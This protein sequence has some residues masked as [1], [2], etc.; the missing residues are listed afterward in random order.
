MSEKVQGVKG[1]RAARHDLVPGYPISKLAEVFGFGTKKYADRNWEMGYD[2]GKSYAAAQ[3]HLLA[4]WNG[5]AT[6][7]ESG[8]PHLAH[9]MWHM[10]VLMEFERNGL[11]TDTRS[12]LVADLESELLN[13]QEIADAK[14]PPPNLRK[15]GSGQSQP[16]PG[17]QKY[18]T[19]N[20]ADGIN[21]EFSMIGK[22]SENFRG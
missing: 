2:W 5:E 18:T 14:S 12:K 6:D 16:A 7:P 9:V 21:G 17:P 1:V 13:A 3:R 8:L 10:A 19:W 11:G 22:V 20:H 15:I 4:W